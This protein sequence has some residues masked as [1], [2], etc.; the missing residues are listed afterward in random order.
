ME[1]KRKV[2]KT[3]LPCVVVHMGGTGLHALCPEKAKNKQ[4][5]S[6]QGNQEGLK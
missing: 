4:Y 2:V 6:L 5:Y 1:R 3:E